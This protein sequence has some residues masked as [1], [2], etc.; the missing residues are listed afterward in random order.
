MF[1]GSFITRI[2]LLD[3]CRRWQESLLNEYRRCNISMTTTRDLGRMIV[4]CVGKKY[5]GARSRKKVW[6]FLRGKC[7]YGRR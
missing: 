5:G 7:M 1:M 4:R 3:G 2:W 6:P